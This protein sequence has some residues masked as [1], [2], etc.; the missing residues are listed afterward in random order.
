MNFTPESLFACECG[1]VPFPGSVFSL[2]IECAILLCSTPIVEHGRMREHSLLTFL[3]SNCFL[4]T[5]HL[6]WCHIIL[7]L[8]VCSVSVP[9]HRLVTCLTAIHTCFTQYNTYMLHTMD[10]CTFCA[11]HVPCQFSQKV[12]S[13]SVHDC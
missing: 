5:H 12:I 10:A 4:I 11:H 2:S 13:V 8:Q 7:C 9:Q 1:C 3:E 6:F